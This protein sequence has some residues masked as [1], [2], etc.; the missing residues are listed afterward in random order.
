MKNSGW[1]AFVI[2][3]ACAVLAG[4]LGSIYVAYD[5]HTQGKQRQG[6]IENR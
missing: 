5:W 4:A 6:A 3:A 2:L 1:N